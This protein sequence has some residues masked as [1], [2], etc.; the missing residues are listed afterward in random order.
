M[1][2]D[3]TDR[4]VQDFIIEHPEFGEMLDEIFI[5][6]K[7]WRLRYGEASLG[8]KYDICGED[9][10]EE[11]IKSV[12]AITIDLLS[13]LLSVCN[14]N[15][16]KVYLMYGSLLGAIRNDGIIHGDDDIDVALMRSDYDTLLELAKNGEFK[17]PYFFQTPYNDE[18]FYGGFSKLRY[19]GT[20]AINPQN[21]WVDCHE[22][23]SID[24]FPMDGGFLDKHKQQRKKRKI[25]H[26]QRLLYAKAYG[27]YASFK[28]MPL[29]TWKIYKYIGKLWSRQQLA[30]KLDKELKLGDS[31]DASFGIYTHY[32]GEGGER[33]FSKSA[34]NETVYLNYEG[35]CVA[36]P[37][38]WD[39]VLSE[40]YDYGYLKPIEY[41]IDKLR[42]GFYNADVPYQKYKKRFRGL[43]SQMPSSDK[44]IVLV[45]D[46]EIFALYKMR[47][48]ESKYQPYAEI[49]IFDA[50]AVEREGTKET[51]S[52]SEDMTSVLSDIN[53][54]YLVICAVDVRVVERIIRNLGYRDY[55]IFWYDRT[56]MQLA[57]FLVIRN[58]ANDI[59]N[60]EVL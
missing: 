33:L 34:F 3:T 5:R 20:T 45:G 4:Y 23:I 51:Y 37:A 10:D 25:L 52:I 30:A 42:H 12:K 7:K 58:K 60:H 49:D 16:L 40:L 36:A 13:K 53:S 28:D 56:W 39:L 44:K 32:M 1:K 59:I 18:C 11:I 46:K 22:G 43:F 21:W 31:S 6:Q 19:S 41:P 55:Y 17:E 26:L 15:G 27:Y 9:Y 2:I 50:S 8:S 35:L 54:I 14:E 48:K 47:Y 38:G 29:L 24:I 57:N